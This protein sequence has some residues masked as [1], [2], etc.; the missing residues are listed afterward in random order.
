MGYLDTRQVN[1]DAHLQEDSNSCEHSICRWEH[2][3]SHTSEGRSRAAARLT[4]YH[5]SAIAEGRREREQDIHSG[6]QPLCPLFRV[7]GT[8]RLIKVLYLGS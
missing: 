7:V 1:D 8:L 5:S 2:L 3:W 6:I 4:T